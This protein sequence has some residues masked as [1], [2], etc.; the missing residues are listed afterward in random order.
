[1]YVE[2]SNP[3]DH[4]RWLK[5]GGSGSSSSSV[6]SLHR[7]DGFQHQVPIAKH[8]QVEACG[9]SHLCTGSSGL[10]DELDALFEIVRHGRRGADLPHCL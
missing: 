7:I 9:R 10:S 1:V 3:G 6:A 4:F 2:G 8:M 5:M